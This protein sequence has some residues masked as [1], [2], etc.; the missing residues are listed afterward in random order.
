MKLPIWVRSNPASAAE[1]AAE[2]Q[3][4]VAA[5]QALGVPPA[6]RRVKRT[7]YWPFR[8]V[9]VVTPGNA[10]ALDL[11]TAVNPAYV[12]AFNAAVKAAGY[13]TWVYGSGDFVVQNPACAGYWCADYTQ[14]QHHY[15]AADERATQYANSL[16]WQNTQVDLSV[17]RRY[18]ARRRL[19]RW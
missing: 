9:E 11:E 10:V 8:R 13:V 7:W 1:G 16:P 3:A 18:F 2:G 5:M 15:P 17:V 12:E 4:A 14:V 6:I 19:H